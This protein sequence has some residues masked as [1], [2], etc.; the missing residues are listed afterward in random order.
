[1]N[2]KKNGKGVL[3]YKS[4]DKYIG[5]WANESITGHGKLYWKNGE[6]FE[7]QFKNGNLSGYGTF[8]FADGRV[9]RGLWDTNKSMEPKLNQSEKFWG[10][11]VFGQNEQYLREKLKKEVTFHYE[12]GTRFEGEQAVDTKKPHKGKLF[13]PNGDYYDGEFV[14]GKMS[15][16]GKIV[17][18]NK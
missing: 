2:G 7:G 9:L 3:Y 12:D 16:N 8:Y 11:N 17:K 4:G 6:R 18:A 5:D 13:W 15:G 14:N 10:S 1:M